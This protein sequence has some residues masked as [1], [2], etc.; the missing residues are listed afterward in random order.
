M[1]TKERLS[2]GG[3]CRNMALLCVSWVGT[4]YPPAGVSET[5]C[6]RQT[7]R[8]P[9]RGERAAGCACW[10]QPRAYSRN[11]V[12]GPLLVRLSGAVVRV[13]TS[14]VIFWRE[15]AVSLTPVLPLITFAICPVKDKNIKTSYNSCGVRTNSL[16]WL[17][18][19]LWQQVEMVTIAKRL[20]GLQQLSER[21]YIYI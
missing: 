5:R 1:N 10:T 13:N 6:P 9:R 21:I 7:G 20:I 18:W 11:R 3:P 16:Q 17:Q 14:Q 8:T 15:E 19:L 12:Q 2:K 4:K